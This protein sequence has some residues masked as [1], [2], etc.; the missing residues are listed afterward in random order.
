MV[1]TMKPDRT[2]HVSEVARVA[3]VSVR[4]LHY[5]EE[6]GL[7]VPAARTDAGYRV[8]SRE[9]LLRLQQILIQRE[10]GLSLEEVRRSLDDPKFDHRTVLL[11]QRE[12]LRERARATAE[13]IRAV[14]KALALLN[15]ENT[16]MDLKEL[17]DGFDPAKYEA[18]AKER[19]GDT[20]AY[21]ESMKRTKRYTK[22]VWRRLKGEQDA[23]YRDVAAAMAAGKRPDDGEVLDIVERHR[24]L[25]D[26]WFYPCSHQMQCG[27]ADMYEAD[28][29]FAENIDKHGVGLT[30]F[31][32]ESIRAIARRHGTT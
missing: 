11:R 22:A 7:L 16:T 5:Y 9:N 24:L 32:V 29:R 4:T 13:M 1:P 6:I 25:I 10:L 3:G 8:Y 31:L 30:P 23:V 20:D 21:N 14:D 26:R 2:F 18:E 17:F 15:A 28:A 19:W 27:L 12:Q